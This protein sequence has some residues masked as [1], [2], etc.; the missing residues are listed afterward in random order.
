MA[1][2]HRLGPLAVDVHDRGQA[3]AGQACEF[4]GVILAKM[5]DADDRGSN[6]LRH[7]RTIPFRPLEGPRQE[8]AVYGWQNTRST[9]VDS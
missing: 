4:F 9:G 2:S 8:A 5:T 1:F 7:L 6:S 3:R